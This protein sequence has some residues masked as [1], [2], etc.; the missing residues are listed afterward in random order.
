MERY[1]QHNA[2]KPCNL[3]DREREKKNFL[4]FLPFSL[5]PLATAQTPRCLK[6]ETARTRA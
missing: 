6:R 3:K 4:L 2:N 1:V 5:C